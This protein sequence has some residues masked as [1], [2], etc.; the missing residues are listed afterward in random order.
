MSARDLKFS[1]NQILDKTDDE[2]YLLLILALLRRSLPDEDPSVIGYDADGKPL[3]AKQLEKEVLAASKRV[4]SG[5][6]IR[7]EDLKQQM[8]NW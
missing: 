7:H 8:K 2:E 1:I 6:F 4:K 3:T 5:K